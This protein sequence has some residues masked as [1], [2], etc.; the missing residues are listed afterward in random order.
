MYGKRNHA[1]LFTVMVGIRLLKVKLLMLNLICFVDGGRALNQLLLFDAA[2]SPPLCL[3]WTR[4]CGLGLR[5]RGLILQRGL[6]F[7]QVNAK[8]GRNNKLYKPANA[9]N[10]TTKWM[11]QVIS[12]KPR[13]SILHCQQEGWIIRNGNSSSIPL[14]VTNYGN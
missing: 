2:I 5:L 3:F 12:S 11:K 1:L 4:H 10:R 7:F 8:S 6:G 14:A 9:T 13:V